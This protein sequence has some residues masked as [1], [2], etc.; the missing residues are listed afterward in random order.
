MTSRAS[1]VLAATNEDRLRDRGRSRLSVLGV[2]AVVG[3]LAGAASA[4]QPAYDPMDP[5]NPRPEPDQDHGSILLPGGGDDGFGGNDLEMYG[6]A[7][8][9]PG[10]GAGN[11]SGADADLAASGSGSGSGDAGVTVSEFMTVDIFVRDEDLANVLQMLSLQSRRNIIAS[12]DVSATV[13]ANLYGVT[14]DEALDAILNV[15]GYG[16]LERGNFIYVYPAE[17]IAEMEA[18][19]RKREQRVIRL[20][21]LKAS[22]AALFIE[23]LLSEQGTITVSGDV[24]DFTI[25]DAKP[26]G[27]EDYALAATLVV[28]DYPEHIEEI[29]SLIGE[30]DQ[31]PA[32]VLV[33]AT[34]L[35][36]QLTEAN[37]FGVDFSI[38][39]DLDFEDFFNFGGPLGAADALSQLGDN[40]VFPTDSNG[41]A[42]TS[43]PGNFGGPGTLKLGLIRDEIALFVRALDEVTDLTVLSNPKILTLN[44]QAARVLVGRKL[45]YLNTTSTETSTTQSV[46]FL[47]TGTQLAVRPFVS[48]D[49]MIR[50]ELAPRV[51]EGLIRDATDATGAAVTIPDEITQEITTNVMVPD[52][53]TIV[54]GGLFK[55]QTRL[56][57]RQVPL[58]G[59][60][61]I[62]GTAF[63]GFDDGTERAEIIFLITPSIVSDKTMIDEGEQAVGHMER[64]RTGSRA[65]M[66][67]WSRDRQTAALNVE[68]QQQAD[69]GETDKALWTI[70]RS[71]ELNPN[72][73]EAIRLREQLTGERETFPHRSFLRS[74]MHEE[75]RERQD[76]AFQRE[77]ERLAA[78]RDR[79]SQ[80]A[81][82]TGASVPAAPRVAAQGGM[83]A[84]GAG[85]VGTGSGMGSG[86]DSNESTV[87]NPNGQPVA[88]AGGG[89]NPEDR[90][91]WRSTRKSGASG[92]SGSSSASV[93]SKTAQMS[94]GAMFEMHTV[95]AWDGRPLD[96]FGSTGPVFVDGVTAPEGRGAAV[97]SEQPGTG[98]PLDQQAGFSAMFDLLA[99]MMTNFTL[100][101]EPS[102]E[103]QPAVV[104]VPV[105]ADN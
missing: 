53:A 7:G 89:W 81:G 52:G 35:Q 77:T 95:E 33:E 91:T 87:R 70:R 34:I 10:Y 74:T 31:R 6:E 103:E 90:L 59:D 100:P 63:R 29:M 37:A 46:E 40:A 27:A 88:G 43:R 85:S 82:T 72:Q 25:T 86:M 2:L 79:V 55:E 30:I 51:S 48:T 92:E 104:D 73:P 3:T 12:K 24:S 94:P 9:G 102:P 64:V 44:R 69:S 101:G 62:I 11:G 68:A 28:F 5:R 17:V 21:Y 98:V 76:L 4:Q 80:G 19:A 57:R 20:N 84:N 60:I 54:L 41:T 22:D 97:A 14:I 39:A 56:V 66:L 78:E 58:L 61:P 15:N 96:G 38:I 26:T 45:G 36:T 71:L 105:P 50:M 75:L 47:D 16:W 23:P 18:A 42:V 65:S 32:Q 1:V 49:G 83:G 93:P 99:G 67:P 13:T 8:G